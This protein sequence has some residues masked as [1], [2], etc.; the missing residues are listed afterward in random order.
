MFKYLLA[1]AALVLATAAY[2]ADE[3]DI[4]SID[5][6]GVITLDNGS[7]YQTGDDVSGWSNGDHVIT[8][9]DKMYN[10]DQDEAVDVSE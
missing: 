10:K 3:G 4:T 8:D 6:N 2:A 9:G 1:A 5:N 7:Q